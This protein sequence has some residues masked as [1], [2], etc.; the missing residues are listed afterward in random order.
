MAQQFPELVNVIVGAAIIDGLVDGQRPVAIEPE[1][2]AGPGGAVRGREALNIG[3]TGACKILIPSKNQKVR[4]GQIVQF[5]G[6]GRVKA[7]A[8]EGVTEN[9]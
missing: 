4:N 2:G 6:N 1:A 7:D 9:D 5:F 3:K 8:V